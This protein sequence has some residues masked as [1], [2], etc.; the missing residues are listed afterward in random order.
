[1]WNIERITLTGADERT[2]VADLAT[3]V[4]RHPRVEVG[5]LYTAT[6]EGRH[7]YVGLEWLSSA[8]PVLRGRAALHVCGR[9]AREQLIEGLLDGLVAHTP[10]VQVNGAMAIDEAER[11][12]ARVRTLITQHHDGNAHLLDVKAPNHCILI[13]ASGGKGKS[14]AGWSHPPT[15]KVT[16]FAGGLGPQNLLCELERIGPVARPEAWVDMEAK[17]RDDDDWFDLKAAVTCALLFDDAVRVG[18]RRAMLT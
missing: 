14:P 15:H 9:A 13:D 4:K 12:A 17:L 6:P 3:L 8:L 1:V 18:A 11:C 16:G 10:R 7:R 2:D 5:L